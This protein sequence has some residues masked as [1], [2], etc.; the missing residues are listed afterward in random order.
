M[1]S[2][3]EVMKSIKKGGDETEGKTERVKQIYS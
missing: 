1:D 2:D 3:C